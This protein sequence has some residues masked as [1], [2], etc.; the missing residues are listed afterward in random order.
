MACL[1]YLYRGPE[2]Q[3]S[4]ESMNGEDGWGGSPRML[5][6]NHKNSQGQTSMG[7]VACLNYWSSTSTWQT[8]SGYSYNYVNQ[9]SRRVLMSENTPSEN[10]LADDGVALFSENEIN[11]FQLQPDATLQFLDAHKLFYCPESKVHFQ[12]PFTRTIFMLWIKLIF[13]FVSI[14]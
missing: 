9:E 13:N 4:Q 12:S 8:N 5:N 10:N 11:T 14:L 7:A 1:S 6:S 2:I 3:A